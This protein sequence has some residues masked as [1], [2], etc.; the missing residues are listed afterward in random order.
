MTP[1]GPPPCSGR[2]G[3]RARRQGG[4]RVAARPPNHPFRG[5]V[6]G[7]LPARPLQTQQSCGSSYRARPENANRRTMWWSDEHGGSDDEMYTAPR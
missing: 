6:G 4:R 2:A 1:L 5:A 7:H 3:R